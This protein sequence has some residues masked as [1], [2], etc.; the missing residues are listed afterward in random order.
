MAEAQAVFYNDAGIEVVSLNAFSLSLR[1]KGSVSPGAFTAASGPNGAVGAVY[2]V[3][4]TAI[5]PVVAIATSA[6]GAGNAVAVKLVKF[7]GSNWTIELHCDDGTPPATTY[8]YLFDA[9]W[10]TGTTSGFVLYDEAGNVIFDA[11]QKPMKIVGVLDWYYYSSGNPTSI[12][13][14]A[15]KRYA[16][17]VTGPQAHMVCGS[18]NE[19]PSFRDTL[20]NNFY[21]SGCAGGVS[22]SAVT[23]GYKCLIN[24]QPGHGTENVG[25]GYDYGSPV[26]VGVVLDVTNY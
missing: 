21:N 26:S 7:S 14:P 15:G 5:T 18:V 24:T 23:M 1:G 20:L 3:S 22:G 9:Y 12:S 6:G 16:V 8:W 10:N 19:S 11:L 4:I 17:A 13:V 25:D 2:A